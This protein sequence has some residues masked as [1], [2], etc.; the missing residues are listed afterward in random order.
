M[1]TS[2]NS[3]HV[4]CP[5]YLYDEKNKIQCEGLLPR[6]KLTT[7]FWNI[8]EK[9]LHLALYCYKGY[10]ECDI[11][12]ALYAKYEEGEKHESDKQSYD[13]PRG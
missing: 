6:S 1:A 10:P 12:K 2:W 8:A 4:R 3:V 7:H 5:F 13:S 11:F 9:D